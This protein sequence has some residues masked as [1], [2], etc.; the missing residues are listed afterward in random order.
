MVNALA[1]S[2]VDRGFESLSG[3]TKN[4]KIGMCCFSEHAELRS[5]NKNLLS[6]NQ[7]NEPSGT[8]FLPADCCFC[9]LA[10][11]ISNSVRWSSTK[12]ISQ[13]SSSLQM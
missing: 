13:Q 7:K 4:Y 2:V 10:L 8:T 6:W 12:M 3:Q 5:N 9:G 11:L 1:S